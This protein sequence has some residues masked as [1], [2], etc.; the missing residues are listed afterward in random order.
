[1]KAL[2]ITLA[3]CTIALTST[4][5]TV[6]EAPITR[7]EYEIQMGRCFKY[8]EAVLGE[9]VVNQHTEKVFD[10]CVQQVLK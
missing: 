5:R 8:Q 9:D 1:M 3:I 6:R 4:L 7:F 10:N 2:S